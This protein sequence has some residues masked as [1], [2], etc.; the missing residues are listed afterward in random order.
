ML[1]NIKDCVYQV[2]EK[3]NFVFFTSRRRREVNIYNARKVYNTLIT[4]LP[5]TRYSV[6]EGYNNATNRDPLDVLKI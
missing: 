6:K 3:K 1:S 5:V 4:D 2:V